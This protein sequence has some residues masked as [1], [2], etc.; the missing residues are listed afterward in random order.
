M[1]A[2][3]EAGAEDLVNNGDS[4]TIYT[5]PKDIEPVR[6]FLEEKGI[7]VESA[8]ETLVPNTTVKVEG[9]DAESLLKLL[10]ALEDHDDV[11]RVSANFEVSDE[12]LEK[13]GS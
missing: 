13:I 12:L 6:K 4:F 2:A 7:K 5:S 1:E 8:S 3:L 9:K 10:N 11:Q